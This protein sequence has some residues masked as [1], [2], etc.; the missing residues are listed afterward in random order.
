MFLQDL[1][2]VFAFQR[3]KVNVEDQVRPSS[4]GRYGRDSHTD[5]LHQHAP[6]SVGIERRH[7]VGALRQP[8]DG[9]FD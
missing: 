4:L 5:Y 6:R 3:R 8:R 1:V 2:P 7:D 9:C